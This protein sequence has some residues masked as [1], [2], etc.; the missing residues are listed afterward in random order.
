MGCGEKM[1]A[2]HQIELKPK[3]C[4]KRRIRERDESCLGLDEDGL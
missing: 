4:K 2:L 1:K 3:Y